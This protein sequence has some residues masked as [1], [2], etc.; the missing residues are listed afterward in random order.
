MTKFSLIL[1]I[2]FVLTGV[3][4]AQ[5]QV[6]TSFSILEDLVKNV[7]GSRVQ[8]TNFVPRNSDAHTYQ[9]STQD[10]KNLSRAK[11]VFINGLGLESWFQKLLNNAASKATVVTV[12]SGLKTRTLTLSEERGE[13]D[14]HLWWNLQN[15]IGYVKNIKAALV[16]A[17][18]AGKKFFEAN[19]SR[20]ILDLSKL[21][22]WAQLELQKI[23]LANRKF[24]TNHDAFGY[25][26]A[27]YGF[28]I[29]G[30]VI[31]SFG[32]QSEPSAKETAALIQNI[33]KDGV[34]AIFTE[35]VIAP[36][37]AQQVAAETGAKI[38]A[39]LYTD[40]LGNAGSEG[41]TFL[42]MFRYNVNIIVSALK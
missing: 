35:N 2:L 25:F 37:L 32:T 19:A 18:P 15:V 22:T 33:R 28:S 6:A 26:A 23:P 41:D 13:V 27:R 20:Y 24:V 42:K 3:G 38:P 31:P 36:K 21:E 29:I 40:A 16:K 39:P 17:D 12:S 7:G 1:I 11:L 4:H 8:I 5:I 34:K 14:P 30:N 9:P 10:V